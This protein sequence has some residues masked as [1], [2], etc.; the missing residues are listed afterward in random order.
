[1]RVDHG[2]L[3]VSIV[4]SNMRIVGGENKNSSTIG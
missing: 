2:W 4:R 1:M 3:P